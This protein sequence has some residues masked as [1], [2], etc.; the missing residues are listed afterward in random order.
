MDLKEK[1]IIPTHITTDFF[2]LF[3][4]KIVILATFVKF[5]KIRK[6]LCIKQCKNTPNNFLIMKIQTSTL[7]RATSNLQLKTYLTH[8]EIFLHESPV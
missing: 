6:Y 2:H 8:E 3:K 1:F 4:N 7:K 5:K